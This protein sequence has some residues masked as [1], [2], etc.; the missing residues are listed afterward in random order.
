MMSGMFTRT[1]ATVVL[2]AAVSLSPA[3]AQSGAPGLYAYHTNPAV[4]GC[5]G[6]DWH[7]TVGKDDSITG[8]VAWDQGKHVAKLAGS[9]A[10]DRTF[11]M[12]AEEVGTGKKAVVK[13]SAGGTNISVQISGSGT[14]CDSVIL[15]IPRVVG[16]TGGGGG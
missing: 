16:G 4:G 10:K 15:N 9:I 13:G 5:P 7:I 11:E 14:A 2:S 12:N 6:L 1:V 3:L 8:F